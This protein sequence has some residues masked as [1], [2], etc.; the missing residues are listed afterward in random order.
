M[1][2]YKFNIAGWHLSTAHLT[3]EEEAIYFRLINFYY[4]TESPIP[5]E[6]HPVIRRLRL[7]NYSDATLQILSEF[8]VLTDKGWIHNRCDE[9]L[10]EYRKT[11]KKNKANGAKGGRPSKDKASSITQVKPSGLP[12]GTQ[13]EPKDNPNYEL[14]TTNQELLTKGN[15]ANKFA[16]PTQE[17]IGVYFLERGSSDAMNQADKFY[18]FYSCKAWMVGKNKMKDWKAAVRNWIRSDNEKHQRLTQP[19]AKQAVNDALTGAD[20]NNW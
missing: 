6:T 17:E 1:H 14:L 8:F 5:E 4:D 15:R 18:D 20:A 12:S 10:K 3:L 19:T 9:T 7:A 11:A 16:V 13:V 2:Y